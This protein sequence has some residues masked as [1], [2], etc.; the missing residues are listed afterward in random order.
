VSPLVHRVRPLCPHACWDITRH[1][2]ALLGL[3]SPLC[4][5]CRRKSNRES[6]RRSRARKLEETH[7]S[8]GRI[9]ALQ[10]MLNVAKDHLEIMKICV[11]REEAKNQQLCHGVRF[12]PPFYPIF[13]PA[14]PRPPCAV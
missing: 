3:D 10:D 2:A 14:I 12:F 5:A 8:E 1:P 6:A 7:E 4:R 9:A 11:L 13:Y